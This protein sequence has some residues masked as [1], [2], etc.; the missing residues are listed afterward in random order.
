M[1]GFEC[2]V[3]Y[4]AMTQVLKCQPHYENAAVKLIF[5]YF[6]FDVG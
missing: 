1:Y 5:D 2:V 3:L 4:L 6:L